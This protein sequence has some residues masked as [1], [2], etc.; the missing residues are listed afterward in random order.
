MILSREDLEK[1]SQ[2]VL[3]AYRELPEAQKTPW[4]VDP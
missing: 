1:I 2:R 4:K 3:R